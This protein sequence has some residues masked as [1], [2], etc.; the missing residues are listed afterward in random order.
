MPSS[1]FGCTAGCPSWQWRRIG[2]SYWFWERFIPR[3]PDNTSV[4]QLIGLGD[5]RSADVLLQTAIGL[6]ALVTLPGAMRAAAATHAGFSR[7][8]LCSRVELVVW[9]RVVRGTDLMR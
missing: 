7:V 8:L 3:S 1:N 2:L 9:A 6:F 4:A 5:S